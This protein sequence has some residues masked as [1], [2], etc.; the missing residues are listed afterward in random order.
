MADGSRGSRRPYGKAD[1]ERNLNDIHP[2]PWLAGVLAR[3]ADT[4]ITKL[5]QLLPQNWTREA[6]NAGLHDLRIHTGCRHPLPDG[7]TIA[8]PGFF[9]A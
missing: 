3:I 2:Q 6:L 5:E 8:H 9:Q 4:T 1:H 7:L